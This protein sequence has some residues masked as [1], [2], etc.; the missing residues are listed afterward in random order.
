MRFL[1]LLAKLGILRWGSKSAVYRSG[2]DRP[3]EL[4]LDN[5]YN[6]ERDLTTMQDLKDAAALLR[7]EGL[8]RPDTCTRCG[9]PVVAEDRFCPAC[10]EKLHDQPSN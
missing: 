7:G 10:G 4:L 3:T 5:V 2:A 9:K 1:D 6:A 8:A